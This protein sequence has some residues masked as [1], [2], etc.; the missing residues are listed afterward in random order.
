MNPYVLITAA[1]NEEAY[2]RKTLQSVVNQTHLPKA[3][4]IVSDGSTDCTDDIVRDFASRYSFI[5]LLCVDNNTERSFSS[6]V[7]ALNAGY[8][9][10]KN[11]E[12]DFVGFL[13]ADI[14]LPDDYYEQLIARFAMNSRLGLAGGAI[15]EQCEGQWQPRD[16]DRLIDVSGQMQFRRECYEDVGGFPPLR[17]GGED[18]AANLIARQKGWQVQVFPDL[19]IRHLR[20]TG[21][22]AASR[23]RARL[24]GGRRDYF[25]GYHPMFEVAKCIRRVI[26]RPYVIGSVLRFCGYMWPCLTRQRPAMP[27]DFIEHLRRGQIAR[28][29]RAGGSANQA[30]KSPG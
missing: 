7:F 27:A 21:A 25:M 22:A 1:R 15:V 10:V 5:R 9:K 14:S 8:A 24:R 13:D 30:Y 18:T 29:L 23:F 16:T 2:I 6:K 11:V 26:E 4:I 12:F 3:W 20:H 28:L 19:R 17:W